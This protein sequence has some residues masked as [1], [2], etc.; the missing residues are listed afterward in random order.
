MNTRLDI[1]SRILAGLWAHLTP[2]S[3]SAAATNALNAADALIKAERA[4]RQ[5]DPEERGWTPDKIKIVGVKP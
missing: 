4:G 3:D 2:E 5:P 1:A